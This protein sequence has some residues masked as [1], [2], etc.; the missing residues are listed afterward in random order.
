M[1]K[2]LILIFL[3]PI[4][5]FANDIKTIHVFVALCDNKNQGIVPVPEKLGNGEDLINNLYWG[6]AYGVKSFFKNQKDWKLVFNSLDVNENVLERVVFWNE[7]KNAYLVAD[8]YRG[9]TIKAATSDLIDSINGTRNDSIHF[10]NKLIKTNIQLALAANADLLAYVGHNGL[11]DFSLEIKNEKKQWIKQKP[12]ILLACYSKKY[13]SNLLE[14]E[15]VNP[16]LWT[17]GL[18]AP[19]AYVLHSAINSWLNKDTSIITRNR[20]ASA[21]NH[22]Q[23]CG[24]KGAKK[25]FS[26]KWD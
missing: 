23:H 12:V 15:R 3:F 2:F 18:L 9:I 22:Y 21:Y 8:A 25:L 20:A 17:N 10:Q 6:A 11:M 24:L 5:I 1:H 4:S 19:E 26:S 16:I 7:N 14:Q 13:F